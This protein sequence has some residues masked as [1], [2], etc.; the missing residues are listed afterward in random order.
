VQDWS[1]T[2]TLQNVLA[3]QNS[4]ATGGTAG[5]GGAAG[6]G[7]PPGS[8]GQP[9]SPGPGGSGPD[10][11]GAFVSN[12]HNL[13]GSDEGNYGFAD[14][15]SGDLVGSST[16][17]N[18]LLGPLANNGAAVP[19]CALLAGS[20]AIDAG[21]DAL[22][23][24]P[25]EVATDQ[26]GL[27]RRTGLHVDIGAFELLPAAGPIRLTV[28][29]TNAL[30]VLTLTNLPGASVTVLASTNVAAPLLNWTVLGAMPETD[31]GQFQF[32]DSAN[33]PLR[34]YRVSSP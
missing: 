16:P 24:P 11:I 3:A 32:S 30:C 17:L 34:F 1:G 20:P 25:F 4:V 22:L 27:P 9:G 14:G 23:D 6:P 31:P 2:A 8:S 5:A 10:L 19:T 7:I 13:I 29:R 12:G 28:R 26:R 18:A 21:D 15:V 33:L